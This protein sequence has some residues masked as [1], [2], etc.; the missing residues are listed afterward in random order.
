MPE[1][2][3]LDLETTGLDPHHDRVIEV[4]AVAFTPERVL[5][6]LER[7]VDPGRSVPEAVLRLTGI[8]VA[9]LRQAGAQ[10]PALAGLSELLRGREP[11]GHG[12]GMDIEFLIAAAVWPAG[13]E[14]LDT[15]DLARILLPAS[16]SHSLQALSLELGLEQPRPH[17]ALDDADATRQLLLR[18]REVAGGLDESLKELM[19]ALVAPYGWPIARFFAEALT[20]PTAVEQRPRR[21]PRA[22]LATPREPV[23]WDPDGMAG[24]LLPEGPLAAAFPEY[25]HRESQLQMLLAVAQILERG[26][27]LVVEAGTGTGKSIAYLIP[28]LGRALAQGEKV[29]VSTATHTLQEQ[30]LTK[31]LP[32]LKEWLPW[33][34]DAVLLKGRSNYISLRR[35][36]RYLAEPCHDSEEL[37]FKLKVLAW[38]NETDSGDRSELRLH[39]KEEV[40][41]T[42]VASDPMDCVGYFCTAEDCYVHRV[43]AEAERADLVIV[44][45][46]LL[47][48]DAEQG[49]GVLP[50]FQH[51]IVDE[52]HHLED[53]ATQGLRKEADGQA[54]VA[55][56]ERLGVL[57]KTVAAQPR[58]GAGEEL[59][60]AAA[61]AEDARR[62]VAAFFEF[63]A[64]LVRGL[65]PD[66]G[67]RDE[68]VRLGPAVRHAP[69]WQRLADLAA[70]ATTSLAGLD[71]TLRRAG[72]GSRDWLGGDEPD[73]ELRELELNRSRVAE[74][75]VLLREAILEPHGNQVYWFSQISR[76]ADAVLRSAPINVGGLLR[77][78]VFDPRDTVI[79]TSAS[80]AVGGSFDYFR[81][82]VGLDREPEM[83]ILASPFDYLNQALVCLPTGLPD[84]QSEDFDEAVVQVVA[85]IARRIGG[86][87][88]ALFTSHRQLRDTYFA[89]KQRH[90]LDDI[91]ILGQGLDGQRR[92]VLRTFQESDRALLLG[93]ASFWEGIDIP[94]DRLSC[95][96]M[97]RLPF[98]VP[99]EP[100][101]AARAEQ[102]ADS[103][104]QYALP[105]AALKLKQG[106]G[107][108][109]RRNSDRG[110]VVILDNRISSRDYGRAFIEVL[111]R[112]AMYTGSVRG[113]GERIAAWLAEPAAT[114]G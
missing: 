65:L 19:L 53:A 54:V 85:D 103:F 88:L 75:G 111:P 31:D 28:A 114:T 67:R 9:E 66:A 7:L 106:F 34:F 104:S 109:I 33:D 29:I 100:V 15:L 68:A 47:L 10:G 87:T 92:Q 24:M 23:E 78:K 79:F 5:D 112:A 83:L 81:Q 43:R 8:R 108:L 62:R 59:A 42:R 76:S 11:V 69:G 18:L 84:P 20:A 82:R 32:F 107:R 61:S 57:I 41:W 36:R 25:E 90:D 99:T 97:V 77:E 38:L 91:L 70:D 56:L 93:T 89:L 14:I 26:G 17:R 48:A 105:M 22:R 12:A 45:H 74:A 30:L 50:E 52:A 73:A 49:G 16:P 39:G 101:F 44:N 46:A 55:L 102:V 110:A 6:R 40:F 35:W 96:V 2:V 3:A 71:A 80:L 60:G 64:E 86:R 1:Y 51:L 72:A 94:G 95:V 98:P 27:R 13:T 113:V 21:G 4:G 63:A 37:R 58:L